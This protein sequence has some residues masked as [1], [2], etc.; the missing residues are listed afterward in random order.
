MPGENNLKESK[1]GKTI[2][3]LI[4]FDAMTKCEQILSEHKKYYWLIVVEVIVM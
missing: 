1:M 2:P 3:N 4:T